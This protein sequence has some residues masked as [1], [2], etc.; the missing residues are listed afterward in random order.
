[1]T[2][3]ELPL[4]PNPDT[5]WDVDTVARYLNASKSWVYKAAERGELPCSRLGAMLGSAQNGGRAGLRRG[6][7]EPPYQGGASWRG[8]GRTG[9]GE[10]PLGGGGE[11]RSRH[12]GNSERRS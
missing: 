1:M 12:A 2:T 10:K 8:R 3:A 6:A 9:R 4:I 7:G 11:S 5:L